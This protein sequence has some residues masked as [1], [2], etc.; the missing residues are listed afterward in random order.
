MAHG[1]ML[2]RIN[3]DL[4]GQGASQAFCQS[5]G[6]AV[7]VLPSD[8]SAAVAV[9]ISAHAALGELLPRLGGQEEVMGSVW[10]RLG[11]T[12]NFSWVAFDLILA[13]NGTAD[14]RDRLCPFSM[15]SA[16]FSHHELVCIHI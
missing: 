14:L 11:V 10:H 8:P 3:I 13:Q 16:L 15:V 2:C 7:G 1:I 5:T 12:W 6:V 9:L 4:Q